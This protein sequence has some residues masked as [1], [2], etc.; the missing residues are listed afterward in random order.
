MHDLI[1]G[2]AAELAPTD[3][4]APRRLVDY[5]LHAS[6]AAGRTLDRTRQLVPPGPADAG[7]HRQEFPDENAALA[8]L[9]EEH[10]NLLACQQLAAN[11][12]WFA[13]V[14]QLA[15]NLDTFHWRRGRLHSALA[16]W[17][18]GLAA[19]DALADPH[20]QTVVHQR[21]GN[22]CAPLGEHADA[23]HHLQ[24][25]LELSDRTGERSL[26]AHTRHILAW[27]HEEMD[28]IPVALE[29]AIEAARLFNTVLERNL[30]ANALNT[31]GWYHALLGQ[32]AEAR[33]RCE[34]GLALLR[35]FSDPQTEAT[36]LDTLGYVAHR[37]GEH[38]QARDHYRRA[39]EMFQELGFAYEE[40]NTLEHLGET[41]TALGRFDEAGTAWRR[42]LDLYQAQHRTAQADRIR[43]LLAA[44]G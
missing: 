39:L 29:H 15:W 7:V 31:V 1:R 21:L 35:D 34:A 26:Q 24:R 38:A 9:T 22:V 30:E 33:T 8:W 36:I 13:A 41:L 25:A 32:F 12:G 23:L 18:A 27:L 5:Y 44:S 17:R 28:D 3:S 42:A 10:T 6:Y 11:H 37:T 20:A 40:A 16:M 4:P 19:A 14:W 43:H 2:Y